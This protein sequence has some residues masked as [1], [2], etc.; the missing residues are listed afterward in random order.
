MDLEHAVRS[1]NQQVDQLL[2]N[3]PELRAEIDRLMQA[4]K[5]DPQPEESE[6]AV[7]ES[8]STGE[9]P[10]SDEVVRELEDFLKHVREAEGDNTID[11]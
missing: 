5:K 4:A 6:P 11:T 3:Q 10:G 9:L 7:P 2:A 1:F 8:A